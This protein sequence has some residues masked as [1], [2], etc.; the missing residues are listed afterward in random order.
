LVK[1][2]RNISVSVTMA[3]PP[4]QLDDPARLEALRQATLLDTSP[5]EVFDRLT[6]LAST[7]LGVPI[8]LV[9]LLD[10]ERQFYKSAVGVPEQLA[11]PLDSSHTHSFC[12]YAVLSGKPLIVADAREHP[13]LKDNPTILLGVVAYAGI[14]LVT[15]DGLVLGTLCAIDTKP[16]EWTQAQIDVLR[17]LTALVVTEIELRRANE[18]KDRFIAML[19]H[20]L[21]TPLM[22]AL[23]TAAALSA[24]PTLPEC[25]RVDVEL[26]HRNIELEV[27]MIDSLLD[28]AR[29]ASGK[30]R[31]YPEDIDAHAL[32]RASATMCGADAAAMAVDVQLDLRASRHALRGDPA[33]LQQVF[34]NLLKN[35]IKFSST[36]NTVTVRSSDEEGESLRIE[37]LDTG[38]G[39][40]AEMLPQ[41]FIAFEQGEQVT[42]KRLGGL[43]LGL[44]ISKGIV[45]AH[46]G[47]ISAFSEGSGKGAT[48]TVIL[49]A[50]TVVEARRDEAA[51][52]RSQPR[53]KLKILL[54]EDHEDS[55][56]AMAR[57]LRKLDHRVT[58]ATCVSRALEAASSEDFDLLISDI[59]LPDG[60]GIQLMQQLLTVRPIKGIA[61]TGY[62]MESDIEQTKE[63]GFQKHLTKP[64]RFV[65]LEAAIQEMI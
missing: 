3:T 56:R 43:G 12:K 15:A 49:R 16:H 30:L 46:G 11:V 29:I 2:R 62:G 37:V 17:D 44:A 40:S 31:L 65:E 21:R 6:R 39:I 23:L 36:G 41:V 60:T 26:I 9:C 20:D 58:E 4:V 33:K 61:L 14:P 32:L 27:R 35:A 19:S 52:D 53:L 8:S 10:K 1:P 7:I 13:V 59:G 42:S 45:E 5:E 28:L 18:A 50:A 55:M 63:A 34:C 54:V 47:T 22:P 57:L 48:I 51:P 38:V 25:F 64:I 24:D